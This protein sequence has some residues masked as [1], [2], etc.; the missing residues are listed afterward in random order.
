MRSKW[1]APILPYLA[2]W[3]G[4]FIFKNAWLTLLGFHLAILLAVFLLRSALPPH[5][6]FKPANLKHVL[7]SILICSLSGLSLYLLWD[8]FEIADDLPMQLAALGLNSSTWFGFIAYFSLVN[9]FVEEYFWR[10]TLGS[11]STKIFLG[12]VI[13]AGFH[14]IAVWGMAHPLSMLF[15]LFVLTLAGWFWRQ[16]YRRDGSLLAPVLSHMAADLS[17]LIA[18]YLKT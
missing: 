14:I 1:F 16:L 7:S 6:F 12:D 13:Y 5:D 2:V 18:V 3:A 4:L 11:N 9:P 15:M 17:I 10:G 8:V